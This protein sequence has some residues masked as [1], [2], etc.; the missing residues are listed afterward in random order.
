MPVL[1]L[2]VSACTNINGLTPS[3]SSGI[4]Q[5]PEPTVSDKNYPSPDRPPAPHKTKLTLTPEQQ[6]LLSIPLQCKRNVLTPAV[7]KSAEREV[8]TFEGSPDYT[9][10]PAT[11]EWNT[12]R[13]QISPARFPHETVPATYREVTE[14]ITTLRRRIEVVGKAATYK[15]INKPVTTKEAYTSWKPGCAAIEPLECIVRVPAERELLLQKFVDIPASVMQVEKPEETIEFKRK[16]LVTP[17]EGHGEPIPAQ[18]KEVKIGRVSKV[19]QL[20]ATPQPD[21]HA[22]VPIQLKMRPERLRS[23]P[24]LCYEKAKKEEIQLIQ[25]RLRQH[26]YPIDRYGEADQQTLQAIVQF[27]QDNQLPIGAV[28]IETLRKLAEN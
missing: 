16:V 8:K 23:T 19:W 28:T 15:T 11:I 24:A 21:Q 26:G 25:Q 10:V 7:F 1:A 4:T 5:P 18:Y 14:K 13:F 2:A 6:Q 22:T 3:K 9:N 27:Q 17:G 20:I 12:V